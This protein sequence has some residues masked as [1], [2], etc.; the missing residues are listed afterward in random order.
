MNT[1][2][3][4]AGILGG[5]AMFIW[6][7]VGHDLLGLGEV[8]MREIPNDQAVLSAMQ[9]NIDKP[10][11][12][13]FPSFGLG[14]N[15]S[16]EAKKEAMKQANEKLAAN[17]SG[18][19]IY[20]PPGRQFSF[21][22]LLGVEFVTELI[23]AILAVFLLAQTNISSFLGRV[24][25]MTVV[26]ILAAITTNVP[27]WNWYGFPTNYTAAYIF[28]EVVGFICVGI[29]AALVLGKRTATAAA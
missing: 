12:Y 4:L 25:F 15:P 2:I 14:D 17:P 26:G 16:R 28:I 5:V 24:G 27:Y 3:L 10:G 9:T 11:L 7:F 23:E 8:G 20:H 22:K 1:R 19:M 6:S 21:S 18:F 29:T 13:M